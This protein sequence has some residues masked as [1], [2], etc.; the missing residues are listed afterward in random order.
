MTTEQDPFAFIEKSESDNCPYYTLTPEKCA[1]NLMNDSDLVFFSGAGFSKAWNSNYPL[2]FDLF[3]ID[4]IEQLNGS[5]NFI[6]LADALKIPRPQKGSVDYAQQCYDYFSDIKFHLD[7]YKRYPSLML[8]TLDETT[9]HQFEK[10][11]RNFI[12]TEFVDAVGKGE[13]NLHQKSNLN[14]D[15]IKVF[16]RLHDTA[17]NLTF[18]STNYDFIIEKIFFNIGLENLNR[19]I[20]NKQQFNINAWGTS[21]VNLF[22]LN[23]G[24]EVFNDSEGFYLDYNESDLTPNII[25]PSKDQN[26]S[27]KYYKNMFA[28]SANSLRDASKLVFVGYS[29]PFEDHTIRL[30]LKSF[31][32]CLGKNKEVY[33]INR[34]LE[35]AL[36]VC[37]K[38]GQL[39]PELLA[40]DS[41]SIFAIDGSLE[42][43]AEFM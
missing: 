12:V 21:K 17:K 13:L 28:K 3:S 8:T 41:N 37:E 25:L 1:R 38:V 7:I 20:V 4:N 24:F 23:G 36:S 42:D 9:I 6:R 16:S 19:G 34:N 26:Y 22:K 33:V 39:Y 2:G 27:N 5:Y 40:N 11:I 15:M 32:D 43:L 10:E 29:L 18:L 14:Q 31:V 35:S 30:L